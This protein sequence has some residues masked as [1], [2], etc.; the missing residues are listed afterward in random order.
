MCTE[1]KVKISVDQA[2]S[3]D[4]NAVVTCDLDGTI[5]YYVVKFTKAE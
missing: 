3:L 4:E 2:A 1:M 5:K